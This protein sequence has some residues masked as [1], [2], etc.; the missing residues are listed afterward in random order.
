M[1]LL[2][3]TLWIYYL[4]IQIM[5]VGAHLITHTRNVDFFPFHSSTFSEGPLRFVSGR[6]RLSMQQNDNIELVMRV[7]NAIAAE[8]PLFA[9]HGIHDRQRFG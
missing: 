4:N 7:Q 8:S 2:L 6:T 9:K 5:A 1:R 3:I